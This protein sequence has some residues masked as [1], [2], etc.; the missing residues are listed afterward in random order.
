M[1]LCVALIATLLSPP[2]LAQEGMAL[3]IFGMVEQASPLVV[4]GREIV[5]PKGLPVISP[6][7]QGQTLTEGDTLAIR[8]ELVAGALTARRILEVYPI[9]GPVSSVSGDTATLMGSPVYVP[10]GASVKKGRWI[11]VSGFWSGQKV[12]TTRLRNLDG[13]GFAH[14]T[15]IVDHETVAVGG[16]DL[17]SAQVP[18]NGFGSEVWTFS[19]SPDGQGLRV[20]LMAKGVFGG[21]VEMVLWQGHA[22]LPIA[23][24]TYMIHGSN[25][26]GTA[27]DAQMPEAGSMVTGCARDGRVVTDTPVGLEVAFAALGCARH[28]PAD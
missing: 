27:R 20:Q 7:G 3:G 28:I 21:K 26:I 6:L 1:R 16:S 10:A 17:R 15:G 4:A 8:V 19:G 11:A 23:S 24:Q 14:L 5:V 22:S 2:V 18:T 9:V 12:I 13:G 25:I